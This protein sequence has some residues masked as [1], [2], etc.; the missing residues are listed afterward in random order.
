MAQLS[1]SRGK[2]M[3]AF[4]VEDDDGFPSWKNILDSAGS[5]LPIIFYASNR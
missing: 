3:T 4:Q 1:R 5:N 2:M